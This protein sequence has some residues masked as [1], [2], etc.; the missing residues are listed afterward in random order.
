MARHYLTERRFTAALVDLESFGANADATARW[1]A[2][3]NGL[4]ALP[5]IALTHPDLDLN[6]HQNSV[7]SLATEVVDAAGRMATIASQIGVARIPTQGSCRPRVVTSIAWPSMST[8]RPG[9][10]RLDV[11]LKAADTMIDWPVEI[12]PRIPPA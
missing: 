1:I 10:G 6:A 11:G 4:G 2:E 7:I 3:E 12:P 9:C 5:M 8:L